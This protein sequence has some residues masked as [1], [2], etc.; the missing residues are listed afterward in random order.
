MST[1]GISKV[2]NT[3]DTRRGSADN[4]SDSATYIN[5]VWQPQ[6]LPMVVKDV[7]R[8]TE[9][10]RVLNQEDIFVQKGW[11]NKNQM[12]LELKPYYKCRLQLAVE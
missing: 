2:E 3:S 10:Y 7:K 12:K 4:R 9:N 8:E 1:N 5:F 6:T 11:P